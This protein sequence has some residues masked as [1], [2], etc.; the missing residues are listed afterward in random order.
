LGVNVAAWIV[1]HVRVDMEKME[2]RNSPQG[3]KYDQWREIKYKECKRV[4][5]SLD[6]ENT[7]YIL[8]K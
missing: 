1:K 8:N 3:R 5:R 2:N 6:V 7:V 4:A